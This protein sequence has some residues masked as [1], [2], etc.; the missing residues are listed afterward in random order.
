MFK[1]VVSRVS[2]VLTLMFPEHEVYLGADL[3]N[4]RKMGGRYC[5]VR[6]SHLLSPSGVLP[7]RFKY[8]RASLS[9]EHAAPFITGLRRLTL[10]FTST[11]FIELNDEN[12][13]FVQVTFGVSRATSKR[14]AMISQSSPMTLV[15]LYS[16]TLGLSGTKSAGRKE[17]KNFRVSPSPLSF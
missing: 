11:Y 12:C 2:Y 17:V 14:A 16:A 1:M 10:T 13:Y 6:S 7:R 15:V 3:A 8:Q 5:G 9:K 4:R